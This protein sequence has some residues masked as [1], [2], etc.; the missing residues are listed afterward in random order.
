MQAVR[1]SIVLPLEVNDCLFESNETEKRSGGA[2]SFEN[3]SDFK[4]DISLT[5]NRFIENSAGLHGGAVYANDARDITVRSNEFV[6][7]RA[8]LNSAG[9]AIMFWDQTAILVHNNLFVDNGAHYG[10]AA[11]SENTWPRVDGEASN[12]GVDLWANNIFRDNLRFW[13]AACVPEQPPHRLSK[14]HLVGNVATD[15]ASNTFA[16][17]G[18]FATTCLPTL[19]RE[20]PWSQQTRSPRS[21]PPLEQ[22]L[23]SQSDGNWGE[24][25]VEEFDGNLEVNPLLS[26]STDTEAQDSMVL[27]TDSPLVDAERRVFWTPT[28]PHRT[29]ESTEA[30]TS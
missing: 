7:N 19:P 29:S 8:G 23:L 27:T 4:Y 2:I 14:Q 3:N 17:L 9:G 15:D 25:T 1:F 5:N 24:I 10:G 26:G 6:S 18:G 30:P 20:G 22:R 16:S 12:L 11:Y 28:S 21:K 13:A